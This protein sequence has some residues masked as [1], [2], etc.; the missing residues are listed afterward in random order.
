MPEPISRADVSKPI[1]II[2]IDPG[3]QVTGVGVIQVQGD[4]QKHIFSQSLKLSSSELAVRLSEIYHQLQNIGSCPRC[5]IIGG[6]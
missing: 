1:T 5:G 2:G 6:G 4:R 3:S